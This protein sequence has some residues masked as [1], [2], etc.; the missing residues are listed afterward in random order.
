MV[1]GSLLDAGHD[2]T[3]C[4]NSTPLTINIRSAVPTGSYRRDE[5]EADYNDNEAAVSATRDN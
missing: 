1:S 4:V 3:M 5:N 2:V